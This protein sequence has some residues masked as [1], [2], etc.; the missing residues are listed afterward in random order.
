MSHRLPVLLA[1]AA[2]AAAPLATHA[3]PAAPATAASGA[4][5]MAARAE[6]KPAQRTPKLRAVPRILPAPSV[7]ERLA[8][9]SRDELPDVGVRARAEWFD[10]QGLRVDGTKIAYR[11][12]F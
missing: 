11:Q 5:K 3:Q 10:D 12:R 7:S 2:L 4:S 1:A 8:A 6:A 9:P